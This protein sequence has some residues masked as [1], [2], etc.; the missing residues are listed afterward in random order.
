MN[1]YN[2]LACLEKHDV[3]ALIGSP[4]DKI[5]HDSSICRLTQ[6]IDVYCSRGFNSLRLC[7]KSYQI[8]DWNLRISWLKYVL[9]QF[10]L[11]FDDFEDSLFQ[12]KYHLSIVDTMMN[13]LILL[14]YDIN[15]NLQDQ[16]SP[17][18]V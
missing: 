16:T 2:N 17:Q 14:Q 13:K 4:S 12:S 8:E 1:D 11:I 10:R 3:D 7:Y 5:L 15:Q 18:T 9:V 6:I